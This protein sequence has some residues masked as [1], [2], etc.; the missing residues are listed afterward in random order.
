MAWTSTINHDALRFTCLVSVLWAVI[1]T[2]GAQAVVTVP[3]RDDISFLQRQHQ[4]AE[5]NLRTQDAVNRTEELPMAISK[6][7]VWLNYVVPIGG[8]WDAIHDGHVKDG[9]IW[10]YSNNVHQ[11]LDSFLERRHPS[12]ESVWDVACNL[13]LIL[14]R[15]A[16]TH[17]ERKYYGS[18]ISSVMVNATR[19]NC[20][21]CFADVFDMNELQ[22]SNFGLTLG[23]IPQPADIIIVADVLYYISWAGLPPFLNGLLPQSWTISYQTRFWRHLTGMA[24]TEVIFTDHEGNDGVKQFLTKMGA[25]FLPDEGFWVAPGTYSRL[26]NEQWLRAGYQRSQAGHGLLRSMITWLAI[27]TLPCMTLVWCA[28]GYRWRS[29]R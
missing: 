17:P 8:V 3:A 11:R 26:Q 5:P 1:A 25:T 27:A 23:R 28:S 4:G 14:G 10:N 7:L 18:D 6:H 29:K 24:K 13:G 15:L 20:P 12:Y 21:A 22:S 2:K 9:G 16:R 19:E